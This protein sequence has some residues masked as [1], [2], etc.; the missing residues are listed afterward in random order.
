M[1]PVP[2]IFLMTFACLP[3]ALPSSAE[4]MPKKTSIQPKWR[5]QFSA[6]SFTV[7]EGGNTGDM[8]TCKVSGDLPV[9]QFS[10]FSKLEGSST[11]KSSKICEN[12]TC[13]DSSIRVTQKTDTESILTFKNVQM[14]H[15]RIYVCRVFNDSSEDNSENNEACS[16]QNTCQEAQVLLRVQ[17]S[18]RPLWPAL[19]VFAEAAVLAIIILWSERGSSPR[20]DGSE[21]NGVKYSEN[22]RLKSGVN[23]ENVTS[24]SLSEDKANATIETLGENRATTSRVGLDRKEEAAPLISNVEETGNGLSGISSKGSKSVLTKVSLETTL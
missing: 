16:N 9:R 23:N 1:V 22:G 5:V 14:T 21:R 24:E 7:T 3:L 10:W 19:L 4:D 13:N 17:S 15:R 20:E 12:N 18:F 2:L 11:N 6:Q 8:V